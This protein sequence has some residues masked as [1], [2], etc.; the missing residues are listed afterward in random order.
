MHL[1]TLRIDLRIGL[2]FIVDFS[3][4]QQQGFQC[5]RLPFIVYIYIRIELEIAT[6]AELDTPDNRIDLSRLEYIC[7]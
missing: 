4:F 2:I 6:N 5:I 7:R 1:I 3:L